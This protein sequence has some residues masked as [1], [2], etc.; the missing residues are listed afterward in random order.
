MTIANLITIVRILLIPAFMLTALSGNVYSDTAALAIFIVASV[1]DGVD[2]YVA[3]RYNQVTT[4]GIFLD[5]LADKLLVAAAILIFVHRGVMGVGAAMCIIARE[6]AV[7]SLRIVA[8][9]EHVIIS[10]KLAGKIKTVV[11]ILVIALLF[12]G[13]AEIRLFD[14]IKIGTAAI[15]VMVLITLVSGVMYFKNCGRLLNAER[16]GTTD[17]NL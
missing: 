15:W 5:P 11:Q 7:T 13:Y 14:T 16:K 10:A 17:E 4:L 1:T 2:G 3:R 6:F 9:G 8:M 12:T